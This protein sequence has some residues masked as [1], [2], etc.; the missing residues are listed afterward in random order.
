MSI[1]Y[2]ILTRELLSFIRCLVIISVF[3]DDIE[4]LRLL[5]IPQST[6]ERRHIIYTYFASEWNGVTNIRRCS[7]NID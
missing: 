2:Y 5:I 1:V 4:I 6:L 3:A 7:I